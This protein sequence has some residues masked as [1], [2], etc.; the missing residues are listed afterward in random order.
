[1]DIEII[2]YSLLRNSFNIIFNNKFQTSRGS[3]VQ[4]DNK[5][6]NNDNLG[7]SFGDRKINCSQIS[8]R[9]SSLVSRWKH[10]KEYNNS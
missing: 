3:S 1:M 8:I 4:F 10:S 2:Y 7:R 6:C 5:R 9:L